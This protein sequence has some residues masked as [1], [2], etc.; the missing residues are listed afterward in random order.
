[1]I[2]DMGF[3]LSPSPAPPPLPHLPPSLPQ[4][5]LRRQPAPTLSHLGAQYLV[6]IAG[7]GLCRPKCVVVGPVAVPLWVVSPVALLTGP[8]IAHRA[9]PMHI[10]LMDAGHQGPATTPRGHV[11]EGLVDD[12]I[13]SAEV[14]Q[15]ICRGNQPRDPLSETTGSI[16]G[17][18]IR[19]T[20][21]S[22][23][24][25]LKALTH[26]CLLEDNSLWV[27]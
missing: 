1:M 18:T 10:V 19:K 3:C 24:C 2:Q 26:T 23:K 15:A 20:L 17:L 16:S 25:I 8:A 6:V 13:L 27:I 11:T 5:L 22:Q 4:A 21:G 9:F 7:G 14:I 12:T